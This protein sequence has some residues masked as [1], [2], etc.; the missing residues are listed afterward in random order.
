MRCAIAAFALPSVVVSIVT[1]SLIDAAAQD[2]SDAPVVKPASDVGDPDE[3]DAVKNTDGSDRGGAGEPGAPQGPIVM[4]L[5]L[6]DA[7]SN[8]HAR[9]LYEQSPDQLG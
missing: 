7:P 3:V 8:R 6:S 1:L 9:D 5:D 2:G 4:G